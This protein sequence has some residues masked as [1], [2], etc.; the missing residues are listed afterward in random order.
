LAIT[1]TFPGTTIF[2][3]IPLLTVQVLFSTGVGFTLGVLNVFFRDIGQMSSLLLQLWFWGTPVVYMASIVP[4]WLYPW[5]RLNPM[6]HF[7]QG[8]Q[9]IFMEHQLPDWQDLA[10]LTL[11]S[12]LIS[13]LAIRLFNRHAGEIVDEL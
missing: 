2:A 12:A 10:L 1:D 9:R 8:Y 5:L 4:D 3:V 13:V 7:V 6:T 11:I